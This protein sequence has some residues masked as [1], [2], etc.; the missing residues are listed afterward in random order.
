[1]VGNAVLEGEEA[2][3]AVESADQGRSWRVVATVQPPQSEKAS[4]FCEPH[5]VETLSGRIIVHFR[6]EDRKTFEQDI[7]WQSE[8]DDG[9]KTW[10]VPHPTP[11]HGHPL[12][13]LRLHNGW[14]LNTH[15]YRHPPFGQR[16]CL[17]RDGGKTW[18]VEDEVIIRDD[19]PHGDLGYPATVQLTDGSLY[20]VYYQAPRAGALCVLMGTRWRLE[21]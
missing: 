11:I 3:V 4:S 10:T 9:G 5:L 7:A 8:S 17:S 16:A 21:G 18:N 20:T 19:G 6:Y 15:G 14:L 12:H 1:M 2:V 13:L